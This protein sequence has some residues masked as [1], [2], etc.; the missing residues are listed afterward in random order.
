[1]M[2]Y[3]NVCFKVNKLFLRMSLLE[4][5]FD[6]ERVASHSSLELS[7]ITNFK[8]SHSDEYSYYITHTNVLISVA[9]RRNSFELVSRFK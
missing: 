5:C 1:M 3:E 9:K 7:Y 6:H 2:Y 4:C 8:L